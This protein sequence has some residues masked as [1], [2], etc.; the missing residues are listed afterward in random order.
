MSL[1]EY[2]KEKLWPILIETVHALVMYPHHKA[3][4]GEV[5][6]H[7]KPDVTPAELA[8]RLRIPLGEALI[9]LYELKNQI[10]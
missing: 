3:Y 8:A 4:T 2:T 10:T 5:I 6:L 7:E 9:I 1:E